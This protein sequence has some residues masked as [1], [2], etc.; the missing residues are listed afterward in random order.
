MENS[1]LLSKSD[2]KMLQKERIAAILKILEQKN[3][4]T[5]KS[6][7]KALN[8]SNATINRDLNLMEKEKL[9][10]RSYGGVELV[11]NKGV[12]LPFRYERM[13]AS[14]IRMAKRAAGFIEN[15]DTVFIDS[16]TTTEYIGQYIIDKEDIT[17]VT[18]NMALAVFLSNY[19]VDTVCLGGKVAEKPYML[20]GA[21]TLINARRYHFNKMFFSTG[22]VNL[23]GSIDCNGIFNPLHEL[24]IENSEKIFF[25]A[26]GEKICPPRK[27]IRYFNDIDYVITD[28]EFEKA[29]Q[30]K[31]PDTKFI[32]V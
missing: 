16:T 29:V 17:V 8:Y 32:S 27:K 15:G 21:E 3:Y 1:Q 24:V 10:K 7:I 31:Y 6:L 26:S 18:N 23:S 5:V 20:L 28:F 22:G 14:K 2:Y 19:S 9:I 13:K 25:M 12:L 4:V 30:D 11:K